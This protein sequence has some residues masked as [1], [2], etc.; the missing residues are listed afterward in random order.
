MDQGFLFKGV[1]TVPKPSC[2]RVVNEPLEVQIFMK[3][4]VCVFPSVTLSGI[5][6]GIKQFTSNSSRITANQK[7]FFL[8]ELHV[9]VWFLFASGC[10]LQLLEPMVSG[11]GF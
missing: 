6:S 3:R 4:F 9:G 8:L 10:K 11:G 5:Q 1:D 7:S 2:C